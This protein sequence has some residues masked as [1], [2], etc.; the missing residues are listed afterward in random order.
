MSR[1]HSRFNVTQALS[2]VPCLLLR[3]GTCT[4][5]QSNPLTISTQPL[6]SGTQTKRDALLGSEAAHVGPPQALR[7]HEQWVCEAAVRGSCGT[8]TSHTGKRLPVHPKARRDGEHLAAS[9]DDIERTHAVLG[10]RGRRHVRAK[11]ALVAR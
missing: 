7:G 2:A 4:Y 1:R 10:D 6:T 11:A 3:A 5:T 8:G 9:L